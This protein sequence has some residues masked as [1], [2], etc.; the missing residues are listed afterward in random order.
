VAV[1]V[2]I[3]V[4]GWRAGLDEAFALVAGRFAQASSRKRAKSYLL[5]LLSQAERKNGWTLAELAGDAT[6]DGMQRLLN[7]YA[8]SADDVRDDLRGYIIAELGDP[9]GVLIADE[10]GFLKKGTMSAGVQRQYSGT[11]G[12][13]AN[14][15]LGVFLAYAVPGG[16]RALIDR[17]LYLPAS[18]TSDRGRCRGAGIGDDVVFATKP[19]LA[20]Q[21][22]QRALDAKV[23]FGWFTGDEAYGQNTVLRDWLEEQHVSYVMAVPKSFTAGTAAGPARADQLARRV[24]SRGWQRLSCGDGAKGPR[25]YDWALTGTADPARHLLIRRP[26]GGGELAFF[27]CHAPAG[28]PLKTLVTVAGTRWAIEECFQAAKNETGLDHY[29]VRRYDAWYRH[30]TLSMLALAFLA[31]TRQKGHHPLWTETGGTAPA[32]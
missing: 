14:C 11:A 27:T 12:R 28:T 24:P 23:P 2:T 18:W 21:M 19:R 7:A 17:E 9:A 3:D 22:V 29:Q 1:Q 16:G 13:V 8:W 32:A 26:A 10:T 30:A 20:R 4:Q 31:V 15:Q 25:W 5:G 6:P